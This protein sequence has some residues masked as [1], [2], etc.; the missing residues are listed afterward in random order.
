MQTF[1][2]NFNFQL[3]SEHQNVCLIF[4]FLSEKSRTEKFFSNEISKDK[5]FM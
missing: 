3:S 1:K 4:K 5:T 2:E